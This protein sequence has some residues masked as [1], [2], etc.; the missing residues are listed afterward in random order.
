MQLASQPGLRVARA[1]SEHSRIAKRIGPHGTGPVLQ[2]A[3]RPPRAPAVGGGPLVSGCLWILRRASS[4]ERPQAG[5][6][7]QNVPER[8]RTQQQP[9]TSA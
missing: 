3:A 8:G 7:P 2:P 5:Q 1:A 9:K 6:D 4:A